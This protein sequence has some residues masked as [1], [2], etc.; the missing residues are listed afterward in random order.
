MSTTC[1]LPS[2]AVIGNTTQ[3]FKCSCPL[4]RNRPSC[5]KPAADVP[6]CLGIHRGQLEAQRAIGVA[7][8][9][10][11]DGLAHGDATAAKVIEALG[12][13]LKVRL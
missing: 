5:C 1:P 6:A 12:G 4:P 11:V 8:P 7:D 10:L 2:A 13:F 9:E 3:P